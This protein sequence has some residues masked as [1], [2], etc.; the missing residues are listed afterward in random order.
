VLISTAMS[1]QQ[2]VRAGGPAESFVRAPGQLVD[3]GGFRLR[4]YCLGSG[5]PTVIFD[6]GWGDW[7]RAWSKVQ[8]EIGQWTRACS[9]ESAARDS[10]IPVPC[11]VPA[12]VSPRSYALRFT[13]PASP[14]PT[15]WW[16]APS[17]ATTSAH[18]RTC[19]WT[20]LRY[21]YWMTAIPT[22]FN[23][24]MRGEAHRGHAPATVCA[25]QRWNKPQW[26]Q[27][28]PQRPYRDS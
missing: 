6:S 7:A 14:S 22:T 5:S 21:W 27:P 3:A 17:A 19:K 13:M 2:A 28:L 25:L 20:R 24:A 1:G 8:P 11:H 12:C 26:L 9:R 15:F 10:A 4:L 23:R 18:L 16:E